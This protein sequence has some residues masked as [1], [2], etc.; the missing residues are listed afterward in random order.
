MPE[1]INLRQG[2]HGA[3]GVEFGR[4]EN[5]VESTIHRVFRHGQYRHYLIGAVEE[6]AVTVDSP[7]AIKAGKAD[8]TMAVHFRVKEIN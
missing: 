8:Q 1:K 4:M 6:L 5:P 3:V 7:V 2:F